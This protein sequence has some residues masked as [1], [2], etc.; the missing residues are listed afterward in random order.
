MVSETDNPNERRYCCPPRRFRKQ[1]AYLKRAGYQ[2]IRLDDLVNFI[3]STNK[4]DQTNKT[5]QTSQLVKP[6]KSVVITFDDG[7]MDNYESALP[8]LRE[9][10]FPATVFVV[11][12]LV[13]KTN[14]WMRAD[15]YPEKPLMGWHE[16]EKM[17]GN[18]ITVG[19]H[20]VNHYQLS[21]LS[22]E[23]AKREIEDSKK[24][25]EDKLGIPINHFAY[26]HGDMNESIMNM[27]KEAGYRTACLTRSGFN[28]KELNLFELRRLEI[29][30]TDSIWQ[31][32]IKLTYGTN[33]GNLLLPTK[34]YMRRFLEKVNNLITQYK[35]I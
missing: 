22:L 5:R 7:Y 26:P 2:I 34:Y 23:D 3:I 33:D 14:N 32:A 13:G 27:V 10:N 35:R 15:G 30:G 24:F 11:S 25:L 28:S 9:Y 31:F 1:M 19:S 18:G 6:H 20:T 21:H 16:I 17:K 29:Y 12:S 4:T 8:I